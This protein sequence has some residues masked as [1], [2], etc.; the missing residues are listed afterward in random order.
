[1]VVLL[2]LYVG[3]YVLL[4]VLYS[5]RVTVSPVLVDGLTVVVVG[6]ELLV[7]VVVFAVVCIHA[8][9]FNSASIC[10]CRLSPVYCR[11]RCT[12]SGRSVSLGNSA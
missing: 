10:T 5:G 9:C 12:V 8:P 2:L 11:C 4:T 3:V 7:A 6:T 1:M